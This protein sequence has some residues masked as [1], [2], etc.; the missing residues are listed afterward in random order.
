MTGFGKCLLR[1]EDREVEVEVRSVNH[2]FLKTQLRL[3][4]SLQ[5]IE[6][7][8]ERL[9]K[10]RLE[11]GSVS[12]ALRLDGSRGAAP[13]RIDAAVLRS[14][15]GEAVTLAEEL[16]LEPPR[17]VER[18]LGLPGVVTSTE[19]PSADEDALAAQ[20]L[21]AAASALDDLV[22]MR[23]AEG[24]TLAAEL[25]EIAGRIREGLDF[26]AS[27]APALIDVYREKLRRRI[28]PWLAEHGATVEAAE[29]VREVALFADRSDIAEE[30]QR[31][32]SHLAQFD[33]LLD[34][35]RVGRKLDF[36][37]QEMLREINTIGS[38][39]S[40][41]DVAQRVVAM[42]AELEKLREQAQNVE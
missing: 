29:L 34:E 18:F 37:L 38:K 28:E 23:G 33:A 1:D 27:R 41:L 14:L 40:D 7:D 25:R 16:G 11:R 24:A 15:H 36:L 32:G 19:A 6:G 22:A 42:K 30:I 10:S 8:L 3:P 39:A 35:E 26:V 17:R 13:V 21:S 2:R 5:A 31:L 9:V 12:L 20:A 4:S